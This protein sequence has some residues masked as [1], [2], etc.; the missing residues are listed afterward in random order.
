MQPPPLR[1]SALMWGLAAAFY[2]FGFFQRVTP[3]SLAPDLMRDFAL[4]AAGLGNLS[5]FYYYA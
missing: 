1:L 3:A 2:L 5:A 4:S